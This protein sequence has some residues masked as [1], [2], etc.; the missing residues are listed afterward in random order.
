M[1]S[2]KQHLS[3]NFIPLF[4]CL[5]LLNAGCATTANYK[6]SAIDPYESFNRPVHKF[7]SKVDSYIAKPIADG[8]RK[9]TPEFFQKGVNNFFNNLQDVTVILNDILQAKFKQSAQDAGRL[10]LNSTVGLGG[11]FDVA[12]KAGLDKHNE[13]FGQTLAVWGL[14]Q[15]SYLVL[16]FLGP[17]T[18]RELPGYVVDTASNPAS[19]LGG[20]ALPLASVN[21]LNSRANAEGSLQFINEAALD[22]YVFM[23]ESYL[24]WRNYQAAD[25]QVKQDKAL[26]DLENELLNDVGNE[27]KTPLQKPVAAIGAPNTVKVTKPATTAESSYEAAKRQF[28]TADSKLKAL[29]LK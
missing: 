24:Q 7:N 29:K 10:T 6:A 12:S 5:L 19:Y 28:N 9:I 15:G 8:Y 4:L 21:A 20:F 16:P 2:A 23:R 14:P 26:D 27:G 13:D 11:L 17:S 25:G 18:F 3:P 22:P 1:K